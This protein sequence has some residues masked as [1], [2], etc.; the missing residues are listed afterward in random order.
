MNVRQDSDNVTGPGLHG[1]NHAT[2][3]VTC[4]HEDVAGLLTTRLRHR[5]T[6]R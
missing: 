3:D 2:R 1:H 4:R 6:A 5:Q